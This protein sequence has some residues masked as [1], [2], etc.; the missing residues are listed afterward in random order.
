[1]ATIFDFL[2]TTCFAG[3]VIGF[4]QFTDRAVKTLMHLL[5]PVGAF[6]IGNQLGNTGYTA[7]ALLLIVVGI[8]YAGLVL[9]HKQ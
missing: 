7:F 9:R 6:A 5:A 4:F 2:T 8:T 3:V 1:M